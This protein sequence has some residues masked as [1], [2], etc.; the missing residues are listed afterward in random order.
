M[1]SHQGRN[2]PASPAIRESPVSQLLSRKLLKRASSHC[3]LET[4]QVS[5]LSKSVH[6]AAM[7]ADQQRV[8][9]NNDAA[10]PAQP[11]GESQQKSNSAPEVHEEKHSTHH[12][13]RR[14]SQESHHEAKSRAP[15][16]RAPPMNKQQPTKQLQQQAPTR[17]S[18]PSQ[19]TAS[20]VTTKTR[21]LG[22]IIVITIRTAVIYR[23]SGS[24]QSCGALKHPG[25][26]P[27]W[28]QAL[29][30]AGQQ[31]KTQPH[32]SSSTAAAQQAGTSRALC[33][34]QQHTHARR[35]REHHGFW[36]ILFQ[37]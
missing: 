15:N 7:R 9:Y 30:T 23:A 34:Q 28:S 16:K 33:V 13:L 11:V 8:L 2:R 37:L 20:C 18:G 10:S 14:K 24:L 3:R 22:R 19:V 6:A 4:S 32:E 31:K 35:H 21:N 1:A 17:S 26:A 12:N 27:L 5:Q 29:V 25:S 36:P